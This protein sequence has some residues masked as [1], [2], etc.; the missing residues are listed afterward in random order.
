[1]KYESSH[2]NHNAKQEETQDRESQAGKREQYHFILEFKN[3][4]NFC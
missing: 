4:V 1:M 3:A 2:G